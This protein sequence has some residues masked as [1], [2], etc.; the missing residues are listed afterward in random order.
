MIKTDLRLD[1]DVYEY[2]KGEVSALFIRLQIKC[3]PISGFEIAIKMGITLVPYS[4]LS[5]HKLKNVLKESDGFYYEEDGIEYIF[6]ND[7]DRSY[8]RQNMTILHEVGHCVLDHTG[9]IPDI[10]E[11]EAKFFAKYAIAPPVLVHKIDASSWID[12]Y[13]AF[14]ISIQAAMNAWS[15]YNSWLRFHHA[16][17]RYTEY[18]EALLKLQE[19]V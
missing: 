1:N 8:E 17:G 12:I 10:E 9:N 19:S 16:Y 15:Y 18:E 7:M 4:T 5:R 3:I 14:D 6:Y 13:E 2:I 11:A